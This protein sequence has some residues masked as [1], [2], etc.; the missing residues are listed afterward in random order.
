[1]LNSPLFAFLVQGIPESLMLI[2]AGLTINNVKCTAKSLLLAA[3][4]YTPTAFLVK[5]LP[6]TFGIHTIILVFILS[7][8][9]N[10]L[11]VKNALRSLVVSLS[12]ITL[13]ALVES[14]LLWS[15]V[16]V[17]RLDLATI[18]GNPTNRTLLGLIVPS[19]M[20]LISLLFIAARKRRAKN[21]YTL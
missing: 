11:I 21:H 16:N 20:L 13:Q 7:I 14:L 10:T 3:L 19:V 2:L 17:F 18:F 4:I 6:F 5:R 9:L 12:G 15:L 8:Y 1:M